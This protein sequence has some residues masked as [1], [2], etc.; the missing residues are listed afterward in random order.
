MN[1][2]HAGLK[3][4]TNLMGI[5]YVRPPLL[6]FNKIKETKNY[7]EY[8]ILTYKNS[9]TESEEEK[10]TDRVFTNDIDSLIYCNESLKIQMPKKSFM[11]HNGKS[12]FA[13]AF[14]M[15]PNPKNGK[16]SYLDGCILGALGLKRQG[17]NA[18]VIC[19]ITPDISKSDK[20]KLEVVFDKVIYVP[21][22]SPYKMK[23]NGKLKTIKMD[24][25]IFKNCPNYTKEHPY[26][27]V[28]FKL[29]IFNPK[30][31]PYEKVCFVDSDL[32]PMNYYDSLFMLNTP[33]G[34]VEYRKKWPFQKSFHWDRCDYLKHGEIIPKIFTDTGT[35]G[36]SDVNAGLMIVSPNQKEYDSLIKEITSPISKW[37]GPGKKHIGYYDMDLNKNSSI[38][39][40]KFVDSSYCYPEQN[41]LTKRYSGK[42]TYVEYS[43][44]SWSLDPCNSFGIHMAAFNP[45]PWF[46]QPANSSV[47]LNKNAI[48]YFNKELN[49]IFVSEIPKAVTPEDES[50]ILE[51]ISISYELFNDLI[52]WGFI[53]YPKLIKF[54]MND[55]KIYGTKISF[56]EDKFK[57][58]SSKNEFKLLKDIHTDD[59]DYKK[60]SISQQYIT[61][62]I[63]NYSQFS[64]KI[65]NKYLSVCKTKIKDRYGKHI[66][67]HTILNYPDHKDKSLSEEEE[68]SKH[69]KISFG[70]HKG[71]PIN[72]LTKEQALYY[73]GTRKFII[74]KNIREAF[75]KSKYKSLVKDDSYYA[76]LK[77]KK[78]TKRKKKRTKSKS[79][80]KKILLCFTMKG[81]HWC[82]EFEQNLWPKL[83]SMNLCSFQIIERE[84]NPK[85]INKYKIKIYPSLVL[86]T[87]KKH[88]RFTKKRTMNNILKF[89]K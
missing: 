80:S 71:K 50:L 52:I 41:Y 69:R 65:K 67:R 16:A 87:G 4:Y 13:Y 26:S 86:V 38:T 37:M 70:D 83:K 10:D 7:I 27:H 43:F 25:N 82:Q 32:V 89:C 56:G 61:N 79:K 20:E 58:L 2:G 8:K 3:D 66:F 18:D 77:K 62:I 76:S 64:P 60:L 55:T 46:K 33:A 53:K 51:N 15:F 45:K 9:L 42:W 68:F 12:K 6:K 85:L 84:K 54:F 72:D 63:N 34:W 44:Q 17:T 88:K 39:G 49:D 11:K 74:S 24:P 1:Y 22:I 28:F 29:H 57:S 59:T 30:L 19:F 47:K 81:C 14:G 75:L 31:F 5:N 48:P 40:Q 21:Y 35:K 78:R 36:A 23:G 73:I